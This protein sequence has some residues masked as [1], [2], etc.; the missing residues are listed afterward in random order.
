MILCGAGAGILS[1]REI[2]L[3][4][5]SVY[6]LV[7]L[8]RSF[9]AGE[10]GSASSSV[11]RAIDDLQGQYVDQDSAKEI[12]ANAWRQDVDDALAS[13]ANENGQ[14]S[15]QQIKTLM[16]SIPEIQNRNQDKAS[17]KR[18]SVRVLGWSL[19]IAANPHN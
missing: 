5:R 15:G 14:V 4:V 12:V 7:L 18:V 8:S 2:N 13:M 6:F 16:K 1:G 11:A 9:Q 19:W 17:M 10:M 3:Q